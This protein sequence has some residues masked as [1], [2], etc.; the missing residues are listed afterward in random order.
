MKKLFQEFREF[1]SKGNMID[2]AVG[3][4][5]GS[6]FSSV[7]NSIINNL[8]MPPLGLLFGDVDFSD[9]FI[10]LKGGDGLPEN[11]TLAM[12]NEAGAVTFNYGQFLTDVINFLIRQ[13]GYRSY[14]EIGVDKN[15]NY[16]HIECKLKH[17]VDP[18]VPCTFKMTS[19]EFFATTSTMYDLI[20]ID[21]LHEAEQVEKGAL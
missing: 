13:Y 3:I 16:N 9:L 11:A 10:I 6:A 18:N 12:A 21:G 4:I 14:L 1:V 19:D 2:L 8:L 7:V 20:F 15:R 5:I 17:G